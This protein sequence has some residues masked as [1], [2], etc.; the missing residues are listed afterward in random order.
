MRDLRAEN[1]VVIS[2]VPN[3]EDEA[4]LFVSEGDHGVVAEDYR[5]LSQL[6]PRE[7]REDEADHEGLD[8]T[9]DN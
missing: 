3:P 7:L 1:E 4:Q 5:L 6:R 8:Q 9:A 2:E